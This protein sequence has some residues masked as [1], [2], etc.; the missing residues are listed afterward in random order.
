MADRPDIWFCFLERRKGQE[1]DVWHRLVHVESNSGGTYGWWKACSKVP[2]S[3]FTPWS[4]SKYVRT[5]GPAPGEKACR[6]CKSGK[7]ALW[8]DIPNAADMV[9][10]AINATT[11]TKD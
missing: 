7:P 5:D 10:D 11:H 2:P 9:Y 8:I 3:Q 6:Y 1:V 4:N